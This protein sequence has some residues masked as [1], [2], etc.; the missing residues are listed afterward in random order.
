[1][2]K[3]SNIEHQECREQLLEKA[4][5]IC[6][7]NNARLTK[8]R[9]RVLEIIC[10][11]P[12]AI[13]AYDILEILAKEDKSAK[14]ITVYRALDFLMAQKLAHKIESTNSFFACPCPDQKIESQ[15]LICNKCGTVTALHV[16]DACSVLDTYAK[17]V[18]FIPESKS[19][20]IHGICAKCKQKSA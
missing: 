4:E 14:P 20:E 3:I 18:G 10:D 7:E 1:M 9:K 6:K 5:K 19:I 16:P 8:T 17:D 11:Q 15:L 2:I 13:K 12:V